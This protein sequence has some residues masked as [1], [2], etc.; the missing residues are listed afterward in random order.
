MVLGQ[1]PY[2][3]LQLTNEA[4]RDS[5]PGKEVE[6]YLS[7]LKENMDAFDTEFHTGNRIVDTLLKMK[8]CMPNFLTGNWPGF[9]KKK[10][11]QRKLTMHG[12]A[13]AMVR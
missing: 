8:Q 4:S 9:L 2:A 11:K 5:L 13:A 3:L 7:R 1:C 6:A 10:P 12:R